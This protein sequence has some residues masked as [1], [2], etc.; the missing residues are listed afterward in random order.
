[1]K[2][3]LGGRI[4]AEYAALRPKTNSYLRNNNNE[5]KKAK[6][7]KKCVIKQKLKFEVYKQ[8]LEANQTENKLSQLEK[9]KLI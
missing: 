6:N 3:E 1:M 5:I 9:I 7:T 8:C 2:D 4:M